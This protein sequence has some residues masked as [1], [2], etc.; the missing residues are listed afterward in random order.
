MS[1]KVLLLLAAVV[2]IQNHTTMLI[3]L[4][5]APEHRPTHARINN[6]KQQQVSQEGF[7]NSSNR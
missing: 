5:R 7:G 2:V 6:V 1:S 4:T 3:H